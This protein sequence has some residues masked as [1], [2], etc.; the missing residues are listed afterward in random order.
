MG[1]ARASEVM[2]FTPLESFGSCCI[3]RSTAEMLALVLLRYVIFEEY[4][5]GKYIAGKYIAGYISVILIITKL[6][7]E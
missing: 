7:I 5:A 3:T 1:Q 2:G 4:I 6:N